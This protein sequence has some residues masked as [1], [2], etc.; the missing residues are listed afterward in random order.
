MDV[1][2][3]SAALTSI[4]TAADI[5]KLIRDSESSL[6]KAEAKLQ[7][8]DLTS[9]L[10]NAKLEVTEVQQLIIEKDAMIR[11]L[12]EQLELQRRLQYEAP[13]YWLVD[14]SSKE[15]P[16]CQHCVDDDAKRV[17]LQGNGSGFWRCTICKNTY[18][19]SDYKD[20][21]IPTMFAVARGPDRFSGF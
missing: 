17:R 9:A 4:K 3:I 11:S 18:T 2:S 13:Y 20:P 8:A 10:A 15:G 12:Q 5:A 1:T 19:D 16:F 21:G 7:L 14:D 6:E